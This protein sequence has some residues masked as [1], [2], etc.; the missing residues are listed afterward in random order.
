MTIDELD[1]ANWKALGV[2]AKRII[3]PESISD[4]RR[5]INS[6]KRGA[7]GLAE[8]ILKQVPK[9]AFQREALRHVAIAI[10]YCR[11]AF[12]DI[13]IKSLA[14][15]KEPSEVFKDHANETEPESQ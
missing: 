11:G 5:A 13:E 4:N 6:L 3:D 12:V 1:E 10:G 15:C 2:W 7:S 8:K 9:G 14:A